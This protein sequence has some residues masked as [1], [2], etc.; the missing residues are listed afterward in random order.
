MKY[1]KP[2]A[3]VPFLLGLAACSGFGDGGDPAGLGDIDSLANLY[4]PA[5]ELAEEE[6]PYSSPAC[7][8][9]A[10]PWITG[11]LTERQAD[12]VSG[13]AVS[14]A[15][16]GVLWVHNDHG[17]DNLLF[18]FDR[19]GELVGTFEIEGARNRDWEDLALGPG[20]MLYIGDLGD[21]DRE[22]DS[23]M[24]YRLPEPDLNRVDD[25]DDPVRVDQVETFELIYEDGQAH[26][27]EALLVDPLSGVLT[28]ITRR[29]SDD[30]LTLVFEAGPA[31]TREQPILLRLTASQA[32]LPALD[33]TVTGAD[34]SPDGTALVVRSRAGESGVWRRPQG[35][36]LSDAFL[37]PVCPCPLVAGNVGAVAWSPDGRGFYQIPE[38]SRP[39]V[40]FT[41]PV[42]RFP[43]FE[44]PE[45]S[46][47]L[48]AESAREISGLAA[49]RRQAGVLWGHNDHG[50]GNLL[51][52]FSPG[53]EH[54]GDYRLEGAENRDW[55]DL[56]MGPGPEAAVDYLYLGDIG[57]NQLERNSVRII[58]LAEPAVYPGN[59]AAGTVV[60]DDF[61]TFRLKYDDDQAH[62]AEALLV[63][64]LQ[65]DVYVVTKV[66]DSD[67]QTLVFRAAAPLLE[68]DTNRLR[69][70]LTQEYAGDLEGIVVAGDVSDD[71]SWMVLKFK[72]DD[73]RLWYRP[74]D[75]PLWEAFQ[76][77]AGILPAADGHIEAVAFDPGATGI[78]MVAEGQT[79]PIHRVQLYLP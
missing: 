75:A 50:G 27:A 34:L 5:D 18:A 78:S 71:G 3:V 67:E 31:L 17:G 13:L 53:G 22:R 60:L 33:R 56:A 7:P 74:T 41:Q 20:G 14:R 66:T 37:G 32:D 46:G 28:V 72:D 25:P 9:F 54:L 12:E 70:V 1:V 8:D 38:G 29:G 64:P 69:L 43:G 40:Y 21:N 23:V 2:I 58:R 73:C 42:V 11:R 35:A 63:D 10:E 16:P 57:D 26:N 79:P 51:I 52:A 62:N 49:S 39:R 76:A 24:V 61:D 44:E 15:N 47:I 30:E 6:A 55:E 48:E 4:G 65:G 19:T 36:P 59:P 45:L 68:E 77:P